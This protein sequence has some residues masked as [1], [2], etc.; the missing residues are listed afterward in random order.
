MEN[1]IVHAKVFPSSKKEKFVVLT[2]DTF[3]LYVREP[4]QHNMANIRVRE[5]IGRH[6][7]V[8]L[9][10]VVIKAGHRARKKT[11]AIIRE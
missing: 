11:L 1:N 2:P 3:E 6:F 8:P 9:T 4:A 7:K 10:Q 5:L